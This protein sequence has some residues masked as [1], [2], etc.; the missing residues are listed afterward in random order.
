MISLSTP[1]VLQRTAELYFLSRWGFHHAQLWLVQF[2]CGAVG[3]SQQPGKV[4]LISQRLPLVE[5]P[6]WRALCVLAQAEA[7]FAVSLDWRSE[8][9]LIPAA[10]AVCR[11]KEALKWR[12]LPRSIGLLDPKE[13]LVSRRILSNLRGEVQLPFYYVEPMLVVF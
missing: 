12:D 13:L 10:S 1:W 9:L 3:W 11:W 8:V 7:L 6:C 5:L 2:R 4:L